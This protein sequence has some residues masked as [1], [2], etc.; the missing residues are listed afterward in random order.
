[1]KIQ[2]L[3]VIFIVIIL[4]ISM[5]LTSYTHSQMKT[6]DLQISYDT[7]LDN[8]TYDALKA[9]QLNTINNTASDLANSKLQDIEASVNTFFNSISTNFNMAGYNQDAL[10]HYVPALVYTMYD[11]YYIYS[12]YTNTLTDKEQ[13][14]DPETGEVIST[15]RNGEKIYGLKP[16]IH[17]SCRYKKDSDI[18]VVITYSL[19]NYITVQG[20]VTDSTGNK[21]YV[22]KYGYLLDNINNSRV[23]YRGIDISN[24]EKL[25]EYAEPDSNKKTYV[26]INGQKYYKDSIIGEWYSYL[27][28]EKFT[29]GVNKYKESNEAAAQ[30]YRDASTFSDWVKNNLGELKASDAINEQGNQI[31]EF[32]NDKIFNFGGNNAY[33]DSNKKSIEDSDSDFNQHRIAVIRYVIEKNLS[34]AIA[35]YNNYSEGAA[36]QNV[37]FQMPKLKEDE[38]TKIINNVSI[39]SF[40]QGLSIGGKMYNGYS[41]ITNTETQEV[42][43]EESIYIADDNDNGNYYRITDNELNKVTIDSDSSKNYI[44]VLNT[45]FKRRTFVNNSGNNLYFY[46]KKQLGSYT[47]IVNQT[48][49]NE[50]EIENIYKYV[51]KIKSQKV[52]QA[53]YTAL[54]RERYSMYRTNNDIDSQSMK[55]AYEM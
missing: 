39:I 25:E 3:A 46:P 52:K 44:G 2:N 40:L 20:M 30:Y 50:Q 51:D 33:S 6:L 35:N 10:K 7:K 42:V 18:D 9:F 8:A 48:A 41:I 22:Y 34:I 32:G 15:Y 43:N 54:G 11:G 36:S 53:Y 49:V 29:Q 5:V 47:S 16:Y 37:N 13:N 24:A 14:I 28:G 26:K 45:D 21:E 19:D 17:Y 1:M 12:P 38:W 4:P 27:N 55:D 31:Q 23:K